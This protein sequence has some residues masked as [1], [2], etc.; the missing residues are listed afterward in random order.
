MIPLL[1]AL[2]MAAAPRPAA[3]QSSIARAYRTAKGG[4]GDPLTSARG[5]PPYEDEGPEGVEARDAD[6]APD[7]F[8]AVAPGLYRSA[9]PG[10]HNL[11]WLARFGMKTILDLRDPYTAKLERWEAW[12]V[13]IRG[14][15]VAMSGIFEPSFAQVDRA[16]A[17]LT[18]PR[19]PRPILVHCL[20][21][22]DR[23]GVVIAAYR[24]AV[25]G[26]PPARAA[27]E[28]QSLGCCHLVTD[29]LKGF[30]VRYLRHRR[31]LG[32]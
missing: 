18:D 6:A 11:A 31:R 5:R 14:E 12:L 2:L 7:R 3:A 13:G 17:V 23:T 16:L 22:Q 4:L 27:A 32:L 30:L 9:Q 8:R 28:A 20:H 26:W 24:V 25:Q 15:N 21:G 19:T 10:R 1:A 29:D